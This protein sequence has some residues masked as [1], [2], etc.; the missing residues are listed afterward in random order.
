MS[1]R[2]NTVLVA[3]AV[4]VLSACGGNP[5]RDDQAQIAQGKQIFRF[6]TFGDETQWT[7]TL[8][9]HEVIR[10]AVDPTTALSVGLKV[11]ADA[12]P[13]SVVAGIKAGTVDMKSPDTTVTLLQLNAIVGVQGTVEMINGKNMLTRVGVTCAL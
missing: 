1:L 7:D 11:D 9:L 10:T 5:N 3:A 2:S 8:R 12:L 4:A 13:A 6:D